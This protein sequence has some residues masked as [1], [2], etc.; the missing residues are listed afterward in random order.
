MTIVHPL[1]G[2]AL[3]RVLADLV[4]HLQRA[5]DVEARE[6]SIARAIG[7]DLAPWIRALVGRTGDGRETEWELAYNG[8]PFEV[9][10]FAWAGGDSLQYAFVVHVDPAF[11][12]PVCVS[13]A[14]S[15]STGPLWLGDDLRQGLENLAA[16]ACRGR[17][18]WRSS[19]S[20]AAIDEEL[21]ERKR[22]TAELLD[23]LGL[24]EVD[25]SELTEGARSNRPAVPAVP[26]GWTFEECNDDV[27]VLA[28]TETFDPDLAPPPDGEVFDLAKELALAGDL[29]A[30]GFF[31]SALAIAKN[32]YLFTAY[33]ED[34]G[35]A[36]A[37][38]MREC[39]RALGRPWLVAR[40][41]TYLAYVDRFAQER[42]PS[43]T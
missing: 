41:D 27:G 33:D 4:E 15:D 8:H 5:P 28:P 12:E 36:S 26:A 14:P 40:V 3:P 43:R 42:D 39:Y 32:A 11:H 13:Y 20:P 38:V 23:A 30:R 2:F 6:R 16:V 34:S 18:A 31:G 24:C 37:L 10:P 22:D 29:V 35:R 19:M 25:A 17:K 9:V 7:G 21:R 1:H